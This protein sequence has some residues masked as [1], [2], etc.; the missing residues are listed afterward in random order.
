MNS[1][2]YSHSNGPSLSRQATLV[3]LLRL[4]VVFLGAIPAAITS[5]IRASGPFT[6]QHHFDG[7]PELDEASH[8]FYMTTAISLV[9]LG[10]AFAGLTIA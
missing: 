6:E 2:R 1:L 5:P 9:L 8:W 7:D 10:G 4:L 3:R